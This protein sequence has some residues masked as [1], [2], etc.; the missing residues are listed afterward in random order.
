MAKAVRLR[1][2]AWVPVVVVDVVVVGWDP[3]KAR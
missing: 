3:E 2:E 1:V